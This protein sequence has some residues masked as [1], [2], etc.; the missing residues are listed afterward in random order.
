MERSNRVNSRQGECKFCPNEP[1]GWLKRRTE[2]GMDEW[3]GKANQSTPLNGQA[4]RKFLLAAVA[5][6]RRLPDTNTMASPERQHTQQV[7]EPRA[8][9]SLSRS[10]WITKVKLD[11]IQSNP[12]QSAGAERRR[13][14]GD[15]PSGQLVCSFAR[16]LVCSLARSQQVAAF[17][18]NF[19]C[20]QV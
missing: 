7:H 15:E 3:R 6:S 8:K 2:E 9:V 16:L 19:Y 20:P 17:V 10:C 12:I 14:R 5:M 18:D 11:L 4:A 13:D 1:C